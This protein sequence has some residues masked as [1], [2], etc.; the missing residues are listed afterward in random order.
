MSPFSR[1]TGMGTVVVH[2]VRNTVRRRVSVSTNAN[3]GRS[4]GGGKNIN[5]GRRAGIRQIII[6][7]VIEDIWSWTPRCC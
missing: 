2:A 4:I 6:S 3:A 1:P 5:G 7:A